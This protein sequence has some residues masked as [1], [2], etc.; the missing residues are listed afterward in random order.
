[1][2]I[3]VHPP[4]VATA[5]SHAPART[6]VTRHYLMCPP[7]YFDVTY[8]I[9]PWMDP[10]VAVDR[11]LARRQ[12]QSL[13]DAYTALGHQVSLLDAV[14][15]LPDMVFA[16]NGAMVVDGRVLTARFA[17]G[18]RAAEAGHHHAWHCANAS[19]L[20]WRQV[21][22]P[23]HVNE[24]E[25]DFAVAGDVV[26]AGHGF[27]TEPR[28]HAELAALIGTQVIGLRLV[29]PRFYRLDVALTVLDDRP[30]QVQIAWYP[31]AFALESQALVRRLFPSAVEVA[32]CDA[33]VMGLNA[34][35]D[36]LNVVLP[37]AATGFIR[38][39]SDRGFRPVPVDL[40]ELL[41]GGGS[42]KCCTQ[43]LRPA[44]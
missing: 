33:L 28:G 27:R 1:M 22:T 24:A 43:E 34:V 26:L 23:E 12:W 8:R 29:D 40:S 19:A 44:R 41:K 16:A 5:E 15:G 13:V 39:V 18:Q 21:E 7:T 10:D 31:G 3:T 6:P 17:T 36:G 9:N 2:T 4:V 38:Q 14:P 11:D 37:A 20:S 32:A 30:G 25:G 35:S 42:A